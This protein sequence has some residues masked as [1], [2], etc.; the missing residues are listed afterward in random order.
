MPTWKVELISEAK[1]DFDRLDGSVKK[2]V[3]KQIVKLEK[4]PQY[5]DPLGNKAGIDLEGYYKL[6]A[7][8]KRIRIVYQPISSVIKVIA[9]DKREDLE[10]YRLAMKRI[11]TMSKNRN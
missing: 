3:L 10:V 1:A 8:K 6:Y 11:R 5:G 2:K 7:D 4:D 9:I